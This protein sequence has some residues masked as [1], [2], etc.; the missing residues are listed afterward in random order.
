M[1]INNINLSDRL[2]APAEEAYRALR[3]NIQFYSLEHKIKTIAITSTNPGEGKSTT[4]TNLAITIANSGMKVL[5]ADFDLRKPMVLK[6]AVSQEHSGISTFLSGMA[7]FTDILK[8]T[9]VQNFYFAPCGPRPPNPTELIN[10]KKFIEFVSEAKEHFDMVIFDTPPLGIVIDCAIIASQTD[11]VIIVVETNKTELKKMQK[12][13][14][15]LEKANAKILGV[16]LNKIKK[17][18]Y[19]EYHTYHDYHRTLKN[20]KKK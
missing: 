8:I 14:V 6:G 9:D 15:Q 11:G 2:N 19:T 12:V 3:A 10:S 1:N 7:D 13:K 17:N 18:D 4:A 16:V 5:L 20:A